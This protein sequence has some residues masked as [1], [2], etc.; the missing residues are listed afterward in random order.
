MKRFSRSILLIMMVVIALSVVGCKDKSV[1]SDEANNTSSNITITGIK[2]EEIT[3]T[4]DEIKDY[5]EVS[6]TVKVVTSS[7]EEKTYDVKGVTLN[8]ILKKHDKSQADYNAVR[9]IAGDGYSIEVPKEVIAIRELIL[10]YEING[11]PLDEKSKPIRIMLTDERSMYCLRN[12]SKIELI[13]STR[14]SDKVSKVLLFMSAIKDIKSEDY[15]Y[16]EAIDKAI[17]IKDLLKKYNVES[18]EDAV[19][20]K[21]IDGLEKNENIDVFK[22]GYLKI[23]GKEAPAFLSP[24]LPKGMHVKDIAMF[25]YDNVAFINIK[26][27]MKEEQLPLIDLLNKLAFDKEETIK[28]VCEDGYTKEIT[29]DMFKAGYI[30]EKEGSYNIAFKDMA[31]DTKIKFVLSLELVK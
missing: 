27:M 22:G 20:I 30:Y 29:K 7:D 9:L 6:Q 25:S 21:S 23:S 8:E 2:G 16:Y 5:K 26:A 15:T 12:L 1:N 19:F 13:T 24:D 28:V 10:A 31:K 17:K 14:K 4:I 18:E 11:K 3:L